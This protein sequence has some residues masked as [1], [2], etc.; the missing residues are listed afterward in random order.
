MSRVLVTNSISRE[1]AATFTPGLTYFKRLQRSKCKNPLFGQPCMAQI[2]TVHTETC[3]L[4]YTDLIIKGTL[5]SKVTLEFL[6]L[7]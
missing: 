1:R 2:V 6:L 4:A 5:H 7:A 3:N